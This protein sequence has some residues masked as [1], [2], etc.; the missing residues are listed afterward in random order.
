MV[1][2][3][4]LSFL[5]VIALQITAA[6]AGKD[7]PKISDVDFRAY[8]EAARTGR[9]TIP[10]EA[11][12]E[13]RRYRYVFVGGFHN[14]RLPGYFAQNA[15][16]LRARGVPKEA[17]HFIFPSS[18][19]SVAGNARAVRERFEEI[20]CEGTEKLIVIAHSRGSCDTLAFALENPEFVAEHVH[21]L[22]LI[23]GPFGGTALADYVVGEGPPM[24][25]RMPLPQR[26]VGQTLAKA[27]GFLLDHG[28]HGGL[29]SLARRASKEFWQDM[30]EEN[31][32]AIPIVSPKTFYITSEIPASGHRFLQRPIASYLETHFGENDGVVALED[33]SLAGIG[34]VLAVLDAGHT[35]LTNRFPSGRAAQRLRK[36][37]VDAIIMSIGEEKAAKSRERKI[38]PETRSS[39]ERTAAEGRSRGL[40]NI[41]RR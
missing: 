5:T 26:V 2:A 4:M 11:I 18:H 34:N 3:S 39:A 28:K 12:E 41:G 8:F 9:L 6:G 19:D 14:E 30:L 38:Q 35:D 22:F 33:Q 15:R 13:A 36:A 23:Q 17:V 21:A 24:D 27:E 29:P 7:D 25:R 32:A 37:V 10:D 1:E 40:F 16:E 20:A 31:S